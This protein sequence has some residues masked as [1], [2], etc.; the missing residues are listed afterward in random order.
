MANDVEDFGDFASAF[1]PNGATN[2]ENFTQGTTSGVSQVNTMGNMD[3]FAS[4]PA[5]TLSTSGVTDPSLDFASFDAFTKHNT[6][7]VGLGEIPDFGQFDVANVNLAELKIPSPTHDSN[8]HLVGG[9]AFDIPPIPDDDFSDPGSPTV[10]NNRPELQHDPFSINTAL[11]VDKN[12]G[13]MNVHLSFPSSLAPLGGQQEQDG[14]ENAVDDDFGDFESSLSI[15]KPNNF[16]ESSNVGSNFA[17]FED[18]SISASSVAESNAQEATNFG[19]LHRDDKS[20][21]FGGFT[22][23]TTIAKTESSSIAHLENSLDVGSFTSFEST[24]TTKVE[25]K[26]SESNNELVP[27]MSQTDD[28]AGFANF[29]SSEATKTNEE[30]NQFGDFGVFAGTGTTTAQEDDFGD[31]RTQTGSSAAPLPTTTAHTKVDDFGAFADSTG[32]ADEFGAFASTSSGDAFGAFAD[33]K[34]SSERFGVFTDRKSKDSEFGAFAESESKGDNFGA[35]TG[36]DSEFGA[37][38]EGTSKDSEFGAFTDITSKGV[39]AFGAFAGSLGKDDE[40]GEFSSTGESKFGDFSSSVAVPI[41]RTSGDEAKHKVCVPCGQ[42][43]KRIMY[44]LCHCI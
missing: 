15:T 20:G 18:N 4:L 43:C 24:S 8:V 31:F 5:P 9:V 30:L 42:N 17:L 7:G 27:E 40:F 41:A 35:F 33:G 21:E 19:Q 29:Q 28:S 44:E 37:F 6:G 25:S 23:S 13:S 22:T 3:F 36:D 1:P 12:E 26:E 32:K 10:V 11:P 38:A 39:E 2:G 34:H 14:K 16:T